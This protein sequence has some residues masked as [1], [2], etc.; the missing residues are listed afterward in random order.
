TRSPKAAALVARVVLRD[1][2]SETA[3][4]MAAALAVEANQCAAAVDHFARS[5]SVLRQNPPASA[6]YAGCLLEM[7]RPRE[8]AQVFQRLVEASPGN[9][10][11]RYNLAVCQLQAGQGEEARATASAAPAMRPGSSPCAGASARSAPSSRKRCATS[12]GRARSAPTSSTDPW[13]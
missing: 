7:K 13:G 10:A 3:H 9:P 6:Q 11:A 2:G 5:A 4:A 1:P 8:A 12:S